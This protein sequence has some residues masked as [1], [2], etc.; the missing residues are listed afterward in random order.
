MGSLFAIVMGSGFPVLVILM[1]K[2]TDTFIEYQTIHY[3]AIGNFTGKTEFYHEHIAP[4]MDKG[5]DTA[6]M[7]QMT[8][9]F[10]PYSKIP[11]LGDII[12]PYNMSHRLGYTVD[13]YIKIF[14]DGVF[15]NGTLY[16]EDFK[17]DSGLWCLYMA[18]TTGRLIDSFAKLR[19]T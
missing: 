12:L 5:N 6:I 15:Q 19:Q 14:A 8:I 11:E 4:L 9:F 1:G 10:E 3:M 17:H 2:I 16:V 18:L 13:H 7:E